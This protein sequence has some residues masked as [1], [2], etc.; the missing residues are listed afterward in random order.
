[1]D[2]QTDVGEAPR[3]AEPSRSGASPRMRASV[4][5]RMGLA[6]ISIV[7]LIVLI[8]IVAYLS[9]A[10]GQIGSAIV[11]AAVCLTILGVNV[12]FNLDLLRSHPSS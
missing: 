4:G 6:V 7:F 5:Y 9:D 1:M 11:V 10:F 12:A 8:N 2:P 3:S